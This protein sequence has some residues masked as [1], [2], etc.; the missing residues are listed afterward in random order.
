[1]A[2]LPKAIYMFSVIPIK[3]LMIYITDI[4]VEFQMNSTVHLETQE[5]L[6]SQ[7]NTQ[8]KK[9]MLKVSQYSTSKYI[10]KQ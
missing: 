3:I 4:D 10:T 8:Q 5:T 7:G 1:M 9:A 6:N 2:I